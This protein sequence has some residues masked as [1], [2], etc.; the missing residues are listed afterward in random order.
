MLLYSTEAHGCSLRMAY[1][2]LQDSGPSLLVVLDT[3]G[4]L[5]G[6]YAPLPWHISSHYFGTGEAFL[7]SAHPQVLL[8]VLFSARTRVLYRVLLLSYFTLL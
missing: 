3:N 7:F 5:F 8:L 6:G 4:H 2:R 1:S